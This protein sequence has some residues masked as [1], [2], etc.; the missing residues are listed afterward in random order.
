MGHNGL[1]KA[2]SVSMTLIDSSFA[3]LFRARVFP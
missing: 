3:D 1:V 2:F